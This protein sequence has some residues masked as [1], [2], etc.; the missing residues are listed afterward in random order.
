[1]EDS[2]NQ[3]LIACTLTYE[4][5]DSK[6]SN[7]R[8][9]LFSDTLVFE[10]SGFN[11]TL[12]LNTISGISAGQYKITIRTDKETIVL[13][14]LGHLYEDFTSR[15]IRAFN[16]I[17]F[18]ESM[19]QEKMLFETDGQFVHD[20][21]EIIHA[22]FRVCE[23]AIAILPDTHELVR[24]PF[25]MVSKTNIKPYRFEIE[26]RIERKY[27]LQK[28]GMNTDAFLREYQTQRKVLIEQTKACL[29]VVA[30]VS[31]MLAE[32]L[33]DGMVVS[34]S[35]IRDVSP[36]FAGALDKYML[37]SAIS[38]EYAFL[39]E[40]ADCLALGIKRGLMGDLTG[41]SIILLAPVFEKNIMFMESLGE[42]ASATY[43]FRIAQNIPAFASKWKALLLNFNYSMLSVNYRREPIFL[44]DEALRSEKHIEYRNALKRIPGLSDLRKRYVGRVIHS[45]FEKWEKS[46]A[47][48]ID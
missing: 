24:I 41:E 45:G 19:M 39:K 28:M 11:R 40:K 27:V 17:V 33:L 3:Q 32:L 47:S 8:T 25:C 22:V 14:M 31:D 16:E 34:V 18:A 1:M 48:Y 43:V 12:R 2:S 38:D 30:P 35:D 42:T 13:S 6:Q 26:D 29:G 46:I 10:A 15:L 36:E 44:S 5:E 7:V 23:T 37:S 20:N 21:N 9:T 4:C